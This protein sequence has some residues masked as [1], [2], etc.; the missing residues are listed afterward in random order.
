MALH[1]IL[2]NLK[3]HTKGYNTIQN[4]IYKYKHAQNYTDDHC[5]VFAS[6]WDSMACADMCRILQNYADTRPSKHV[7]EYMDFE[8]STKNDPVCKL[9]IRLI[10]GMYVQV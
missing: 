1:D 3:K 6:A 8:V 7:I 2:G 9:D 5:L 4:H 10:S